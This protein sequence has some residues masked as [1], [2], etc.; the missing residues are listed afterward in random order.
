MKISFNQKQYHT[1]EVQAVLIAISITNGYVILSKCVLIQLNLTI[2]HRTTNHRH[3][4]IC[5]HQVETM[6]QGLSYQSYSDLVFYSF[7]CIN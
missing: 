5:T 2:S 6:A 1:L 4:Q 7:I 3:L